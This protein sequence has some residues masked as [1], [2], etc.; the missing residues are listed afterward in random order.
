MREAMVSR[1]VA[2][3]WYGNRVHNGHPRPVLAY[4]RILYFDE[5]TLL[6]WVHLQLDPAAAPPRIVRG[7]RNLVT[8]TELA[9]LTGLSEA[10]LRHIY[11]N[12]ALTGHPEVVHRDR[13]AL[14]FDENVSLAWHLA[15]LA[16]AEHSR[17]PG[18]LHNAARR[19]ARPP[20]GL[21]RR[22]PRLT[23][24]TRATNAHRWLYRRFPTSW[25]NP[26]MSW[27]PG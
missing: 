25:P 26:A 22:T 20:A 27:L 15:R 23:V 1:C 9:H 12:R 2:E 5:A 7:G 24:S 11:A 6:A 10:A 21:G 18:R 16:A 8:R 3:A 4:G 17:P 19:Q 13:R 14:Y